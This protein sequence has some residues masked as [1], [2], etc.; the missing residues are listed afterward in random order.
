[1]GKF[2]DQGSVNQKHLE[3]MAEKLKEADKPGSETDNDIAESDPEPKREKRFSVV[4]LLFGDFFRPLSI[5]FSKFLESMPKKD[6]F[7]SDAHFLLSVKEHKEIV[8]ILVKGELEA[9]DNTN[10][11][12]FRMLR[13]VGLTI[14]G[15][16][17]VILI[18]YH[19]EAIGECIGAIIR[20]IGTYL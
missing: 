16:L 14:L 9:L 12:R 4:S 10:K 11:W 18:H 1:M 2:S 17:L 6:E 8:A 7:A 20:I 5:K 19:P 15:V 3:K 13:G